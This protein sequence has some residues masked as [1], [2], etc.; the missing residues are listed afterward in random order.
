VR[1]KVG[2]TKSAEAYNTIRQKML[3][4]RKQRKTALLMEG[5]SNPEAAEKRRAMK[6]TAKRESRKR[7]VEHHKKGK[8]RTKAL[9][10]QA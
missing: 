6:N 9:R 4:K 5:I 1:N 2:T 8:V 3:E 7:K 10:H